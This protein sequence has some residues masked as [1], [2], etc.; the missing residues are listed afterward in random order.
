MTLVAQ[1]ATVAAA[2]IAAPF[3]VL[4]AVFAVELAAGLAPLRPALSSGRARSVAIVMPANDEASI[5]TATLAALRSQLPAGFRVIVVAD[6]CTDDTAALAA[7]A[8]AEVLRRDDPARRGKGYALAHARDHLAVPG[9]GSAPDLV[10]VLDADCTI[11]R[12]SLEALATGPQDRPLQAVYLLEA[13]RA[14]AP[15]VQVSNFAFAI[16]NLVRQRGLERL[17]GR[18]L[19]TGTGMAFPWPIYRDAPLA[20]ADI[21]ED[22]ALG[23]ELARRGTPPR[24]AA[25]ATVW[26]AASSTEGTMKQRTRWEGGF[27]ATSRTH[28]LPAIAAGLR[29]LDPRALWA[30]LSLAVPPLT[31][32]L[33]LDMVAL[34]VTGGL[35]ALGASPWPATTLAACLAAGLVM[36]VLAWATAGRPF[37]SGAAAARLPLYVLWK[38]PLYLRLLT[39]RPTGW[40]RPG[41]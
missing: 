31:L 22:L 37:L 1:V 28:A 33:M 2:V 3:A 12:A 10:I 23:L 27:I 16:K 38:V 34:A 9:S 26:S 41:R 14:A 29:R 25:G 13:D 30:G 40:L 20:T 11:D 24:L 35:A 7:A 4:T 8:G 6:N 15:M 39:A 32:L 5:I 19:L 21:V 17:A 36:L 18:V